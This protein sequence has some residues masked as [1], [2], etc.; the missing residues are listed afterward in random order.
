MGPSGAGKSTL[1]YILGMLDDPSDGEYNFLEYPVPK[2]NERKKT[3]LHRN[4]I[5]FVFQSYHLID[6]MTVYENLETPRT[7]GQSSSPG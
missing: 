4:F 7:L 2:M 1:L 5:G 3:E 6:E